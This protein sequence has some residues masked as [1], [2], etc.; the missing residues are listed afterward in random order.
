M[1]LLLTHSLAKQLQKIV[2]KQLIFI[3]HNGINFGGKIYKY[4]SAVYKNKII[5]YKLYQL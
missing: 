1:N 4:K 2:K 5:S 3:L